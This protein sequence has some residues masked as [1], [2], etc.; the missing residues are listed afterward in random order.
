MLHRIR[1]PENETIRFAHNK[2]G[3]VP[4]KIRKKQLIGAAPESG[5]RSNKT[6]IYTVNRLFLQKK[7]TKL[8]DS[9][10]Q[11]LVKTDNTRPRERTENKAKAGKQRQNDSLIFAR[12]VA[13][14]V[15]K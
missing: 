12:K 4:E 2:K 6:I 9:T 3:V 14:T 8:D 10:E 15:N 7:Y 1:N 11:E 5:G 13:K